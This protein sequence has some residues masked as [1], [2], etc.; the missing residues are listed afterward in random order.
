[1]LEQAFRDLAIEPERAG[2]R[3]APTGD[4]R[5]RLYPIHHSRGRLPMRERVASPRHALAFRFDDKQIEILHI[6]HEQMDLPKRL[7]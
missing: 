4:P 6:L 1:M 3:T 5:I 2:V 7:G